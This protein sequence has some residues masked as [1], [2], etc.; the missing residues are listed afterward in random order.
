MES[1]KQY[2]EYQKKYSDKQLPNIYFLA[3]TNYLFCASFFHAR[4]KLKFF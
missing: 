2:T 3:R 4:K 1:F